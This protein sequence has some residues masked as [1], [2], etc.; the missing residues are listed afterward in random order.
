MKAES[1]DFSPPSPKVERRVDELLSRLTLSE[2]IRLLGGQPGRGATHGIGH[3]HI[4]ELR[5]SDGPMGVHWW[6]NVATAYP[7]LLLGAACWDAPL[8]ERLGHSLGRDARARGVHILLAPG[9]NLYR[10]PLCGRNF[11]YAGEDPFLASRVAVGFVRGVQAE[12][13]CATVKHYAVNFQEYD[14]H[15]VSSDLDERTLFEMYLPAFRAAVVEAGC[16]AVMAAY[17]LVNGVHCSEHR[18]LLVDILKERWGFLGI[19]MSDWV[20]TYSALGAAENGLDLEMP[21]AEWMTE[22]HLVPALADGRLDPAVID[23]KVRRLLRVAACFGWLDHEQLDSSI[24]HEDPASA[25][26]ALEVARGGIVLLKNQDG[27]LPLDAT[28]LKRIAVLG[29]YAHPAVISGG[30]SAKTTPAQAKSV[31]DGLTELLGEGVEVLHAS[32]PDPNPHRHVFSQSQFE[33]DD[34]PGLRGEY[35]DHPDF[36]GDPVLV[37]VDQRM[38]FSWGPSAP[39][40]EIRCEHYSVRWTG[41]IRPKK[42][43]TYRFYSQS[44]DSVYRV[45]LDADPLIDTL[46]AERNGLHVVERELSEGRSYAIEVV[47]KKTRYF[48][49]LHLGW[50]YVEQRSV[51]I[52]ACSALAKSADA[53]V[54]CVGF[55]E[56]SEGEGFDRP[57][58]MNQRLEQLVQ[59]VASV[60][61]NTVVVLT[62]GGNVAMQGFIDQVR[63]LIHAFYPGQEGGRAIAEILLGKV[64]PSGKLPVTFEREL[65]DRSSFDCYA[66]E[67]HDQRVTLKDGIFGGYRHV[68]AHGIE[69]R[70]PFGFGL[71]YTS[72]EYQNLSLSSQRIPA[73]QPATV[74]LDVT[75]IGDRQ[76]A[77]VVQVYVSHQKS[78]LP[79]PPKELKGFAKV[80]LLPKQTG[81]VEIQLPSEAFAHYDPDRHDFVIEPGSFEIQIGASSRDIRLRALLEVV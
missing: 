4:P 43:G 40:A 69:P 2:K 59:A 12:G 66:D 18:E 62:A 31:L 46:E 28:R 79:R 76:G 35:F 67:D 64:N 1:R 5:M 73:G 41:R 42:S 17:N 32:G 77:E 54:V 47:W 19:V 30:G 72:F 27:L 3:A 44:H 14:R 53:A 80:D 24:A 74:Q 55:D 58:A 16:G 63:G 36:G 75:N 8:W 29:P 20:A 9:V 70:F 39:A 11:E 71:S 49:G 81:R 37:R 33:S 68:D 38:D 7:A 22:E 51:E 34:G 56:V 48:S 57:F 6:C 50:E 61:P 23:D 21:V 52:E 10:S 65:S 25:E 13:V 60:Q 26:V 15:R 45:L 78:R